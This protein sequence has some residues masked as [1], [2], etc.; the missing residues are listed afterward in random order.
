MKNW[1][2]KLPEEMKNK[3]REDARNRY[4]NLSEE[5]K[6]KA[7]DKYENLS[8]EDKNKKENVQ[9]IDILICPKKIKIKQEIN[10]KTYLSRI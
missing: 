4:H 3:I 2:A 10:I 1:Y 7:R 8:K 9:E 5:D 6:N